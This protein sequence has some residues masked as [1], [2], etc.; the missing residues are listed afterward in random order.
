MGI[1]VSKNKVVSLTDA[2]ERLV[3]TALDKNPVEY[4][5]GLEKLLTAVFQ[6]KK[7]RNRAGDG[8]PL[9]Y[10]LKNMHKFSISEE[11]RA[12]L[13]RTMTAI[14]KRH[15]QDEVFDNILP[16]PSSKPVALWVAQA[17]QDALDVP[18]ERNAFIKATNANVLGQLQG[19][20]GLQEIIE[21]RKLLEA[22]KPNA[23]FVMK[24]LSQFQREFVEPIR[25]N[26]FF[27]PSGRVLVVDDLVS[28]GST[29]KSAYKSLKSKC[30]NLEIEC[31]SLLGPVT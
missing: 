28:S 31:L 26:P 7:A 22:N 6:R 10:A 19:V 9:I 8:N 13:Q 17:C 2:H 23:T 11:D 20:D 25:V 21:L 14:V 5:L 27:I 29:F 12:L 15:Y 4:D 24:E 16:L 3:V 30:T 1:N 18:I